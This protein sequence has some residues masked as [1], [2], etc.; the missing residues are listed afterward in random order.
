M[1]KEYRT[2]SRY[3][4]SDHSYYAV[5]TNLGEGYQAGSEFLRKRLIE[6]SPSDGTFHDSEG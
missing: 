5:V 4:P 1:R 2:Y 6:R 3:S